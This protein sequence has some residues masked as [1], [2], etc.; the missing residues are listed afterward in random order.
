[1]PAVTAG[2]MAMFV[3]LAVVIAVVAVSLASRGHPEPVG[4]RLLPPMAVA[5]R[6]SDT[7]RVT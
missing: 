1:M 6:T 5:G 4:L 2:V 3:C 7:L